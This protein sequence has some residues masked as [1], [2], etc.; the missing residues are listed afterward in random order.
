MTTLTLERNRVADAIAAVRVNLG[1]LPEEKVANVN[2]TLALGFVE[3]FEFQEQQARAH[4]SGL[5][6]SAEAQTIYVALGEH[7]SAANGGWAA[8]VDVATKYAVTY[9]IGMLLEGRL[10]PTARASARGEER[11]DV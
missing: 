9:I 6:S 8:G 11:H 1:D 2:E 4:V 5:L 7:G 10:T 3:H